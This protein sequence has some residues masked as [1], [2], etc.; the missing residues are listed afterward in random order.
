MSNVQLYYFE[1]MDVRVVVKDGVLLWALADIGRAL[2]FSNIHTS[3]IKLPESEKVLPFP[4][5]SPFL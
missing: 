5:E 4:P 2:G 3:A 1:G